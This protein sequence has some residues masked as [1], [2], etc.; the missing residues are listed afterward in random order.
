MLYLPTVRSGGRTRWQPAAAARWACACLA[1]VAVLPAYALPE[2]RN[3]L[4]DLPAVIKAAAA[5]DRQRFPN[6]D[7]VLI[8]DTILSEYQA[9]GTAVTIDDTCL[10][11]LTEKGRRDNQTL[12]RHFTLPFGTASFLLVQVIKPDGQV[13]PVDLAA[14]SRTMVDPSQMGANIYNPDDKVLQV[15]IPEL[16]IGD[17]VRYVAREDLVKP[18][19]PNTFSDYEILEYTSPIL[20]FTYEVN[21]PKALPL[22]SIAVKSEVPGTVRHTRREE[23]DRLIYRWEAAD[24]PRMYDEPRM[25]PLYTVV[26]RLLVSTIP[27]WQYLSTW[28]WKLSEPHLQTTPAMKAKVEELTQGLTDREARLRAIFRFVSQEIRYMGITVEKEAPGYEPHDVRLT[29]DNRHGVC[30]DKAALLVAMLRLADITAYPVLI[31]NGPR[32]DAE[33]PQPYFNH[34]IAAAANPDGSYAL[35]DPTDEN[36]KDLFP[37]YLCNQSYL[38]ARPEGDGLRTSPIVPAEQNLLRVETRGR[39]DARGTLTGSSALHFDGINDN[40]YR[41]YFTT[42]K[43]EERRRF[44]EGLVKRLAAGARLT[45]L[46]IRPDNLMDTEAPLEITLGFEADNVPVSDGTTC[47]LPLPRLGTNVGMVNFILRDAGLK[48]RKY[49]FLTEF[50]C[51]VHESFR[52]ELDPALG[53]P[54]ALPAYEPITT[55]TLAWNLALT[56][57]GRT[58]AGEGAFTIKTVEL[59]PAQYADMKQTLK[60]LEV[61]ARKRP[62]LKRTGDSA[63]DVD[64]ILLESV[65]EYDLQDAAHWTVLER[66]RR[67]ILTYKG[68]KDYAELK[69]HYNPAWEKVEIVRAAVT[70]A[71]GTVKEISAQETNEMDA[72]WVASAPRYPAGKTLV[73]SLPAVEV[74]CVIEY[75]V[76]RTCSGL[77]FFAT[78]HV[79]RSV[80]PI[81]RKVVRL[82]APPRLDLAIGVFQ[83]GLL[84]PGAGTAIQS[85]TTKDAEG[86]TMTEWV[87]V[88]QPAIRREDGLPP[89]EVF[90]PALLISAGDWQAYARRLEQTLERAAAS[91]A[92]VAELA[93]AAVAGAA[94]DAAAVRAL[95]DALVTRIR[96]AGP[97]LPELPLSAVSPADV[98]LRDGYGNT[99]DTAILLYA[100]LRQ[101]GFRPQFVLA[102]SVPAVAVCETAARA[103]PAAGRFPDVLVRVKVP[104]LGP[105]Y[106]N[107]TDQYAILGATA[108]DGQLGLA[109]RNGH[110]ERIEAAAE[111]RDA[112]EIGYA[113]QLD[114]EGNADVS[115]SRTTRGGA[116]G[117]ENRK[118]S[119]MPPE[120]RRRYYEETV[121]GL[122]QNAEAKGDLETDFVT[123]PGSERFA[124]RVT[125]LAVRDG[126]YLY[127]SLPRTLANLLGLRADVRTNPLFWAG[128]RRFRIVTDLTLPPGFTEAVLTPQEFFWNAPADAGCVWVGVTWQGPSSL[129]LIHDVDLK[130]AILPATVYPDLL[131]VNRQ[132]SHPAAGTLLLRRT[133]AAHP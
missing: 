58:L 11:V 56:C 79:F 133:S 88:D 94:D 25:P 63:A 129:R 91:S 52:L 32:K 85:C 55:E 102:S 65:C 69:W 76:R 24:V 71:D 93:R 96:R 47:M 122:S 40:A 10:K 87:A 113:I 34:A 108:H 97:S 13:I 68:K 46:T 39:I 70:A 43:P 33:V 124:A 82:R 14:Q 53:T 89:L 62:I 9:D 31:H 28:Y 67:K 103:Y 29:F 118:F 110:L 86:R 119:E 27:D 48:Q 50:A 44:F 2:V 49:P 125:N 4:L 105:V 61:Y 26:Q 112:Q 78:T 114:A 18:R 8:D 84:Q 30:R 16:A 106:L 5:V 107:D 83:G 77:P 121:A 104:G 64:A 98:T 115:F 74:G 130:T 75:E 60:T 45:A 38:V 80:D 51:G 3:G 1:L 73:A 57:E 120:E 95:R 15:T 17:L 42:I 126:D 20:H 128:P 36:T 54:V 66:V 22:R 41:G 123:Y 72:G 21:G 7:D 23:G 117:G 19:V 116:Y 131:D 59:S 127:L 101:A 81:Q 37:A 12:S 100:L 92:A 132:L 35:M 6:A 111:R 99:T 90:A 109:V